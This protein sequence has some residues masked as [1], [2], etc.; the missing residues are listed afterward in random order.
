MTQIPFSRALLALG[1][2]WIA[3]CDGPAAPKTS[4]SIT[5][6]PDFVAVV[7]RNTHE[8]FESPE[9]HISQYALWLAVRPSLTANAGVVFTLSD[10]VFIRSGESL[11]RASA[12]TIAAGDSIEVWDD[13]SVAEGAAE[14]PPGSPEYKGTQA[15]IVRE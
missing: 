10:P 8:D 2:I 9:G 11:A 7:T 5:R 15:V 6:P 1:W 3:A 12:P 13:G 14:S 4:L